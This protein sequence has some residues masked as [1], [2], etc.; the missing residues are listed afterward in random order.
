MAV[1]YMGVR[2]GLPATIGA[3]GYIAPLAIPQP[4]FYFSGYDPDRATPAWPASWLAGTPSAT[5]GFYYIDKNHVASTDTANPYGYPTKPRKTPVEGVLAAGSYV[6]FAGGGT[7]SGADSAGDRFD[8]SG[9]GTAA[10][11]I[12]I[13]TD[14]NNPATITDL[15][16]IGLT[17][18]AE[19]I[20][21]EYFKF[22]GS[23]ARLTIAPQTDGQNARW[24]VA[25]YLDMTG[26]QNA[27]DFTAINIGISQTSNIIPNS[28]CDDI[29][30]YACKI[31]QYGDK[32]L[33]EECGVYKGYPTHRTW[34]LY[35]EIS[36]TGAD[37]IAGSHYSNPTTKQATDYFIAGN[38]VQ[39]GGENCVDLKSIIRAIV[40]QNYFTGLATREQGWLMVAHYG[41]SP[42]EPCRN[43]AVVYNVFSHGTNGI[44]LGGSVGVHDTFIVARNIFFDIKAS[45]AP[46]ADALNGWCLQ[47]GG[48]DGKVF[49]AFNTC[50]DYD[51]G[52]YMQGLDGTDAAKIH[53]NVFA[54][55]NVAAGGVEIKTVNGQE[56]HV[57]TDYNHYDAGASFFWTNASKTL[58]DMQALGQETH[59]ISSAQGLT[60][61]TTDF[62]LT[63]GS[64]S[65]DTCVN[66]PVGD[67]VDAAFFSLFGEVITF[68]FGVRSGV[69]GIPLP[70][71]S[72]YDYGASEYDNGDN[73]G[74]AFPP[75]TPGNMAATAGNT[76][77]TASWDAAARATGYRVWRSVDDG[78]T[79]IQ[80]GTATG[81]SYVDTS[82]NN[83]LGY[84]YKV[85][86]V[87]SY[88]ASAFSAEVTAIAQPL[89]VGGKPLG[90]GRFGR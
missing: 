57:S 38:Y 55:R 13:T 61:P 7:Y 12:W 20:Y 51:G 64:S 90:H 86:A 56:S 68:G 48:S 47:Y 74:S 52:L 37:G 8:W 43:V 14:A 75:A 77:V 65:K 1:T 63:V 33:T 40:S 80:V 39:T 35:C 5:A 82:V 58:A 89:A 71:N 2:Y 28:L 11:P 49:F 30:V 83:L 79:Y 62:T 41:A 78:A 70:Q 87:N 88:G 4:K 85:D 15:V 22:T 42:S 54:N 73:P 34:V 44:G 16:H 29:I 84:K 72:L 67:A 3:G 36:D 45:Y 18:T 26:T 10:N 19:W 76:Q 23:A 50:Y 17:G 53:G 66:G 81:L 6:Y 31:K 25:R 9:Q 69:F 32:T 27:N 24:I 59:S 60:S 21:F 46:Q